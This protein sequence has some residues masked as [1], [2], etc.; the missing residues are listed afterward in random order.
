MATPAIYLQS[1]YLIQVKKL[2]I[3]G[4]LSFFDQ[5]GTL[6]HKINSTL[7]GQP[8]DAHDVYNTLIRIKRIHH[9]FIRTIYSR[10]HLGTWLRLRRNDPGRI[11]YIIYISCSKT[12]LSLFTVMRNPSTGD[13][14]AQGL[15]Q[16]YFIQYLFIFIQAS[17]RCH[18]IHKFTIAILSFYVQ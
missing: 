16:I 1:S 5:D 8:E 4:V 15:F 10:C 6:S 3:R 17:L 18:S 14:R 7:W 9:P 13:L 2:N 11:F 12:L